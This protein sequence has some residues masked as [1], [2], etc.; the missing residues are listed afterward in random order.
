MTTY[1]QPNTK[2][3]PTPEPTPAPDMCDECLV[4]TA[5]YDGLCYECQCSLHSVGAYD[6][7]GAGVVVGRVS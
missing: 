7:D 6:M 5:A 4:N 1:N 3:R 2:T